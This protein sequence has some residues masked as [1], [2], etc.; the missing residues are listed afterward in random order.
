MADHARD[1]DAAYRA[2]VEEL[3]ASPHFGERWAQHWLDVI[4]WGLIGLGGRG[5]GTL[6]EILLLDRSEVR[7][8]C[9]LYPP[10]LQAGIAA[11]TRAGRPAP[12]R[13]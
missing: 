9:D 8:L 6:R 4:R 11:V 13:H 2:L 12:A 1:A 5:S 10:A 3:L 7:A